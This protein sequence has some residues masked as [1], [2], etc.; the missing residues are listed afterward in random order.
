MASN[1]AK[2]KINVKGTL[3]CKEIDTQIGKFIL[4]F[5]DEALISIYAE[6]FSHRTNTRAVEGK[7]QIS[8]Q[9]EQ[10]LN[11]YLSGKRKSFDVKKKPVGTDFQ[12]RVWDALLTIPYGETRTY[13]DI[14]EQVNCP[15]GYRAVGLANNRNPLMIFVPCHRV[16]GADGKLVGFGGGLDTKAKLLELESQNI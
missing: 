4:T 9:A 5:D 3:M 11:E 14:A 15:K 7:N 8:R 1:S 12:M 6:N 2:Q 16:I 10:E 13:K